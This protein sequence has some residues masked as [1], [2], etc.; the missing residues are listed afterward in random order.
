MQNDRPGLR[1][2]VAALGFRDFRLYYLALLTAS[3]GMQIQDTANLYKIYDLTGS[4]LLLGLT[5]LAR[6][7]PILALSLVGGVIADRVDRRRLIMATQG[8]AALLGFAMALLTWAETLNEWHI[9]GVVFVGGLLLAL[10]SP[11]RT[12]M[13][14]NL[15]P[16]DH[17]LNAI[18]LNS[19]VWQLSNIVGPAVAGV[20]IASFGVGAAY[21][22]NGLGNTIT[23]VG[24]A[25]MTIGA[26]AAT[27]RESP[28]KSLVEGLRFVRVQSIILV[29]LAMDCAATF[30]GSYRALMPVVQKDILGVGPEGLGLLMSAPAVGSLLG[31]AAMMSLGDM[32]Y[33]GFYVAG[34]IFAYCGA[35]FL[36]AASPWL[37]LS[38]VATG[39]LG[40]FDSVQM[41]PRNGLIQAITPDHLRGRVS[42]FQSMLTGGVPS[43]GQSSSGA[44]AQAL[45]APGALAIGA[46]TCVAAIL[47]LLVARPDLRGRDVGETPRMAPVASP[48]A[49]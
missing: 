12:A 33:K 3:M 17:L 45:G 35:L 31:A 7:V 25:F 2:A 6:A 15:V 11:A 21:A 13:I 5:G 42:A 30:F 40:F 4:P 44:L 26:V 19:T 27:P 48:G 32:R 43:L 47:G 14:P 34:G 23:L 46:L 49:G 28:I 29:L 36:L 38:M 22:L 41:V 10:S 37:S 8:V 39:L 9:Y 24:L 16:R 1:V 20:C 18:A